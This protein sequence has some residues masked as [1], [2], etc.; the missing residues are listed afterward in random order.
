MKGKEFYF[1]GTL[2]YEGVYLYNKKWEGKG[3]D[4]KGNIIYELTN[5]NGK[6]REYY[7][8]W[9]IFEGEYLNGN[10]NGKGKEYNDDGNVLFEGEYLNGK[11]NGEGKEYNYNGQLLFEGEYKNDKKWNGKIK[12]YY[13]SGLVEFE[14]IYLNNKKWEGKGY[15]EDGNL[16]Y[17]L[18]NGNGKVTEN[19]I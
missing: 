14:G 18:I 13:F 9:L 4:E 16:I 2:E 8:R 3:Y 6:I 17:E 15:D 1:D 10:R 19:D 7:K 5:G 11:R 12:E